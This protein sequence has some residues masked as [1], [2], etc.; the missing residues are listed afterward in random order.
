[1]FSLVG[2]ALTQFGNKFSVGLTKLLVLQT[3]LLIKYFGHVC[4]VENRAVPRQNVQNVH[5]ERRCKKITILKPMDF[6]CGL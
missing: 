3:Q 2:G 1:M 6:I 4:I 5:S